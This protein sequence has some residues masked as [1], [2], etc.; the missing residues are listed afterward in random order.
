M[1]GV[2]SIVFQE[3]ICQRSQNLKVKVAES[4]GSKSK[5]G[6]FLWWNTIDT[7]LEGQGISGA[8]DMKDRAHFL[9]QD[10][11]ETGIWSQSWFWGKTCF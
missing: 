4:S 10:S 11:A 8:E 6:D 3:S 5:D 7:K 1:N 9:T 2:K